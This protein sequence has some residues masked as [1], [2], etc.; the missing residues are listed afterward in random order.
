MTFWSYDAISFFIRGVAPRVICSC[1][2]LHIALMQSL[3]LSLIMACI[4]EQHLGQGYTPVQGQNGGG[5]AYAC[6][7][8]I[9]T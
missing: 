2:Q 3:P 1:R 5:V 8:L 4:T 6:L 9:S 7:G